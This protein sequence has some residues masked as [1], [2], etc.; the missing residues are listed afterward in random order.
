VSW[1]IAADSSTRTTR[2]RR[3]GSFSQHTLG[4][5]RFEHL[6]TVHAQ[7]PDMFLVAEAVISR[8]NLRGVLF[9]IQSDELMYIHVHPEAKLD[10]ATFQ[11]SKSCQEMT[12]VTTRSWQSFRLPTLL[13]CP[14]T[15][16]PVS[17]PRDEL[18]CPQW[19][20]QFA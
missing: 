4:T 1:G 16:L 17:R 5:S 12:K 19:T 18:H 20:S 2:L 11:I 6:C 15:I 3:Q 8:L 9:S 13:T 10:T 14:V 7:K